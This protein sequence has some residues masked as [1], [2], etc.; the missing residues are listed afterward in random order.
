[1]A[2]DRFEI[3]GEVVKQERNGFWITHSDGETAFCY[4]SGRLRKFNITIVVGDS[5]LIELSSYDWSK[6]RITKRL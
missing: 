6:G 4:I 3:Q 2:E 1:M 5:V